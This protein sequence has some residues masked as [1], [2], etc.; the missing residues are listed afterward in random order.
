ASETVA[1]KAGDPLAAKT[2]ETLAAK[3]TRLMSLDALRGFDMFWIVG[4]EEL[5]AGLRKVSDNRIVQ[6]LADQLE[7]VQ[8]EGF[9]FEDLIFPMFVFIAGVSLVFSLSRTIEQE[10][11]SRAVRHILRRAVLFYLLGVF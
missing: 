8:W 11:R 3:S 4:A 9:H 5:V 6:G 2:R 10:G 1:A 7:H